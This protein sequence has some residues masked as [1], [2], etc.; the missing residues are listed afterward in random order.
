MQTTD[1]KP[2]INV[3]ELEDI[4]KRIMIAFETINVIESKETKKIQKLVSD[5]N[6][7]CYGYI[8]DNQ[9]DKTHNG[10]K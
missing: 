3:D 2:K 6:R 4:I 9:L 7:E 10:K 5:V 8:P 1:S